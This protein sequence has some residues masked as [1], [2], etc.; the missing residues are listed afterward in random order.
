MVQL[1]ECL[2]LPYCP[3]GCVTHPTFSL[4]E[5]YWRDEVNLLLSSVKMHL[6]FIVYLVLTLAL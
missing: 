4:N 3:E 2:S 6:A 5:K 1:G